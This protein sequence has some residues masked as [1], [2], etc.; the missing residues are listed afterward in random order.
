LNIEWFFILYLGVLL[1]EN[2]FLTPF[3]LDIFSI[4]IYSKD[5]FFL[6]QIIYIILF[7][8]SSLFQK[9]FPKSKYFLWSLFF[10]LLILFKTIYS[11]L[12]FGTL[13]FLHSR[14]LLYFFGNILFF[15]LCY[16]DIDR[17]KN[18]FKI[19][20]YFGCVYFLIAFLRYFGI[21]PHL[22]SGSEVMSGYDITFNQF[23]TLNRQ[24]LFF[25]VFAALFSL[26]NIM[27][28]KNFLRKIYSLLF[29][30]FSFLIF[31]S[32][33]RSVIAVYIV[34]LICFL[35]LNKII[36]LRFIVYSSVLF[37]LFIL[38]L[39]YFVPLGYIDAF[40]YDNLFGEKSTFV[41]RNVISLAYID[42]MSF[43]DFFTGKM[44]GDIPIIFESQYFTTLS[45]GK[46]GVHNFFVELIY[47]FGI[48]FSLFMIYCYLHVLFK[49]N[50]MKN[51]KNYL[52]I[53]LIWT[54]LF[55]YFIFYYA[56]TPDIL[57]A[58]IFGLAI[59]IIYQ[60]YNKK[61]IPEKI[62]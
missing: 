11:S 57:N 50:N 12:Y 51:R 16:F 5:L 59:N 17:I 52:E 31:S 3:F 47:L 27:I 4:S 29:L 48:F 38:V 34:G 53:N 60:D 9:E 43:P 8:V 45:A 21:L 32:L 49:L 55:M 14:H 28:Y 62:T 54:I 44:F 20:F 36:T 58:I 56:W 39:I 26:S 40:S 22:Y 41:W 25:V 15:S 10:L 61:I 30:L 19:I 42:Y 2:L 24:S 13:S 7:L 1:L 46:A 6:S 37:P 35:I 18:I 23:R 33:T